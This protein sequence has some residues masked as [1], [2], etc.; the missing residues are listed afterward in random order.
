M[1]HKESAYGQAVT[2][3]FYSYL[4]SWKTLPPSIM[5]TNLL[6]FSLD[7]LH[8]LISFIDFSSFFLFHLSFAGA[9]ISRGLCFLSSDVAWDLVSDFTCY[10]YADNSYVC[11]YTDH[12]LL[13]S[14]FF[15]LIFSGVLYLE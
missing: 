5:I 6:F 13:S 7:I 1:E 9:V 4:F 12:Y 14:I 2:S 15:L 3:S 8:I 10:L 11:V